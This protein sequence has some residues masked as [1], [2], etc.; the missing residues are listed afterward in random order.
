MP[1]RKSPPQ[2]STREVAER[3]APRLQAAGRR[4][5]VSGPEPSPADTHGKS[6]REDGA[7][8]SPGG[9][10]LAALRV[11]GAGC[12]PEHDR[13]HPSPTSPEPSESR[14]GSEG[15]TPRLS[16]VEAQTWP[17]IQV[18][19]PGRAQGPQDTP[20]SPCGSPGNPRAGWPGAM[21]SDCPRGSRRCLASVWGP[22]PGEQGPAGAQVRTTGRTT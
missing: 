14:T 13:P 3:R 19:T 16:G 22:A 15:S 1:F 9:P 6:L 2:T 10:L 4:H 11:R 18:R 21:P 8:Q 7:P 12:P 5:V 20:F 17:G